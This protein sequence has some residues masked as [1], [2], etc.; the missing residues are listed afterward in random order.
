MNGSYALMGSSAIIRHVQHLVYKVAESNSS[1]LITGEPGTGKDAIA[2]IIHERSQRN[3]FPFVP[4]KC[5]SGNEEFLEIELFGYEAG[6][7][8]QNAQGREG[9]FRQAE[10]GVL[11]LDEVSKLSDKL[12]LALYRV[13]NDGV[14][15]S[16]GG[17]ADIPINIRV[18]CST[19]VDLEQLVRRGL[20]REDLFYKLS[21]TSIYL[22]PIRERREDIPILSE[23]FVQKFNQLKSKKIVGISHDAMN[24]LLQN[25]WT[26]NI[27]ELENLIERI[28][29][30][31]NSGS[32]EISDL[33]P[34]LRNLVTD[35]IDA[36]YDRT[37]QPVL[38]QNNIMPQNNNVY[39]NSGST[40]ISQYS[41]IGSQNSAVPPY[42]QSQR[43][44]AILNNHN[45]HYNR[46]NQINNQT[47][48]YSQVTQQQANYNQNYSQPQNSLQNN[49]PPI[50]RNSMFD[51]IPSE[52]DQFIKKEIDLGSGIDFYRVVEEF[53]NRLISEALRRTNHNKNRA[54]QLLS[55]NRTTLVEKLK[56]RA[57]SSPIKSET[58]RVKRNSAFTIFDGL[59]N[60]NPDF[61]T[62]DFVNLGTEDGV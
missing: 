2:K 44:N 53:E 59:G 20:F 10:G 47:N 37:H 50:T 28:V 46:N 26:H 30:L 19:S 9:H 42:A 6:Y 31:K 38:N 55:M 3:K 8:P 21:A 45:S 61:D 17:K 23:Y 51:D 16:L 29:V 60:D 43:E 33:P 57:T 11:Y 35:N 13:I 25:V 40:H 27:Q 52:I 18:I 22:P 5:A 15:R 4:I 14:I 58:G 54:A 56:K 7:L 62:I 39:H 41:K 34:R 24:A 32:I 49:N 12:Q 36:F 48:N 1:I